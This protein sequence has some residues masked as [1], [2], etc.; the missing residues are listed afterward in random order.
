MLDPDPGS[1]KSI[2]IGNR[3]RIIRRG[4]AYGRPVADSM[5]PEDILKAEEDDNDRGLHFLCFNT[6]L[7]RQFEFI[8]QTWTNSK[9]FAGL[10]DDADPIVGD[11]DPNDR[12]ETGVFTMQASPIR[13]R[14][15]GVPKFVQTRGGAY[16]FMPGIRAVRYLAL[17][18]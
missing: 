4:R 11:Q 7:G 10:Y 6:N 3:H 1:E 13:K 8:Q 9:K 15:T 16:F 12:G 14:I 17:L 2:A 18:P 5:E